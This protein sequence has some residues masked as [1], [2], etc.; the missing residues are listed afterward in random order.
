MNIDIEM[1]DKF[2]PLIT[3]DHRYQIVYGGAG[4]GKSFAIVQ[5]KLIKALTQP[6]FNM[7]VVRNTGRSNRDSTFALINQVIY[8]CNMQSLFN[9]NKTDMRI[10]AFNGNEII[11]SG[12]DDVEKLKSVTFSKGELT[13]IWVE[14][15]SEILESDFNQLD[16]RLRGGTTKKVIT[17]S[18]NPIDI[19]HWLKHRFI[20][21]KEENIIVSHSTYKDNRFLDEDYKALLESYKEKDPYYY[22]VYCL[23]DWG[24]LGET[25]F[26]ARLIKERMNNLPS[27]RLT[28]YFDYDK[29]MVYKWINSPQGYIKIYEEPIKGH[30]YC[31]GGDTASGVG[32]DYSICQ[33]I[34]YD[35]GKQV[36]VLRNRMDSDLYARQVYCLGKYYNYALVSIEINYDIYP[37]KKL[38][39]LGY[40]NQYIREVQDTITNSV[41][42]AFGFRTDSFTRPKIISQLIEIVREHTDYFNDLESLEEMLTFIRRQDKNGRVEAQ[43]GSHDDLVMALAISYECLKQIKPI[44]HKVKKETYDP[45]L[46]YGV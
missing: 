4:S 18:F 25:V 12:L 13:D 11:F 31:I 45:F 34:D 3:D 2:K 32:S 41:K 33:V 40:D 37:I 19:N 17:I 42:K 20:D 15:A 21:S 23:G 8:A 27:I 28:G 1:N 14:E 5:V 38:E 36:A 30:Q 10:K 24:I 26:D 9:I 29:N 22:Q 16:V 43:E 6:M 44:V 7:L 35:T 46:E 39:E